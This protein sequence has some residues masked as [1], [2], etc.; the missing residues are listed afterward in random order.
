MWALVSLLA[1]LAVSNVVRGIR[2]AWT[3]GDFDLQTRAAE[4]ASFRDGVFPN[5]AVEPPIAGRSIPYSVYPPY[6]LPLFAFFFEPGGLLQGRLLVETLSIAGLIVIG[7]HGRR[8]LRFAGPALAAVGAF[9]G[10]AITGTIGALAASQF[11]ILCTVL[12]TLQLMLLERRRPLAAGACWALAM[13]KPQI[14]AAFAILFL[15]DRQWRGLVLGILLLSAL[16]LAACWW[17]D[18]SPLRLARHV[19]FESSLRFVEAPHTFGPGKLAAALGVSGRVFQFAALALM[20]GLAVGVGLIVRT[21]RH[22]VDLPALAGAAGAIGELLCYH[23]FYDHIMLAPTVVALLALA[24]TRPGAATIGLAAAMA[25]SVWLPQRILHAVP[26]QEIAR[27]LLWA[28]AG[29]VLLAWSFTRHL[30][31]RAARA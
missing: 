29:A 10:P 21:W 12:V 2:F 18:V 5:A 19:L 20:A 31:V 15:A 22:P 27:A 30:P 11:S 14:G 23:Q 26:G 7:L 28:T 6:A 1:V 3:I 8:E 25:V 9:A 17:T 16:S 13:L 4:Y 24:A